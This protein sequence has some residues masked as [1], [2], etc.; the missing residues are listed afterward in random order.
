MKLSK[1]QLKQIIK[2]ELNLIFEDRDTAQAAEQ[3]GWADHRENTEERERKWWGTDY[4]E[5]YNLGYENAVEATE[6]EQFQDEEG[7]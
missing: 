3:D 2:E 7:F 1:S 6:Y 5:D 4:W